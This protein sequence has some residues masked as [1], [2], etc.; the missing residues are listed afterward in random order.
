[1]AGIKG[2]EDLA[3]EIGL[4]GDARLKRVAQLVGGGLGVVFV[5]VGTDDVDV[6]GET[7]TRMCLGVLFV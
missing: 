7:V 6:G 3:T 5:E 2:E 4:V 1:M